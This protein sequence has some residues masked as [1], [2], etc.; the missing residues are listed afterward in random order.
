VTRSGRKF[1]KIFV[2]PDE[3]DDAARHE[4]A[5]GRTRAKRSRRHEEGADSPPRKVRSKP[6]LSEQV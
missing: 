6:K 5:K 3:S 2:A 1:G 4:I